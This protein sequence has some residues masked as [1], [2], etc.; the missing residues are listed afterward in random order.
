MLFTDEPTQEEKFK[1]A[2]QQLKEKETATKVKIFKEVAEHNLEMFTNELKA[3]LFDYGALNTHKI[4]QLSE[5]EV[6]QLGI[7][8]FTKMLAKKSYEN[9]EFYFDKK[10]IVRQ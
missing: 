8:F 2:Q 3:R 6:R 4:S 9:Q 10:L 7:N 1:N 5:E